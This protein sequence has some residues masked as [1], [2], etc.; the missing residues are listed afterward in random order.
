MA[1]TIHHRS[2]F[3]VRSQR[4]KLLWSSTF[5]TGT[6]VAAGA[7]ANDINLI[8]DLQAAGVGVIGGTIMRSHVDLGFTCTAADTAPGW[9]VGLMVD[10]VNVV[11]DPFSDRNADWM[12]DRIWAPGNETAVPVLTAL[13]YAHSIDSKSKRRIHEV[14]DTYHL[15]IKNMGSAAGTVSVWAKVLVALP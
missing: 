12:Y 8:A 13:Q 14:A 15:R 9:A 2:S 1:R 10:D 7:L 5:V 6:S 3:P 4:R 11:L